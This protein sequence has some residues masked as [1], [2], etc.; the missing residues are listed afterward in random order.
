MC[1]KIINIIANF[2]K[3][4]WQMSTFCL[5]AGWTL[6]MC[7]KIMA[8]NVHLSL[9]DWPSITNVPKIVLQNATHFA[10]EPAG[11]QKVTRNQGTK[12]PHFA[13]QPAGHHK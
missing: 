7:P 1:P 2:T 11:H 5:T 8:Q 4:M 12:R 3:I 13:S 10:L 6:K 9:N